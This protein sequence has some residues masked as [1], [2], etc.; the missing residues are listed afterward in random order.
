MEDLNIADLQV[1]DYM[2]QLLNS[3][4]KLAKVSMLSNYLCELSSGFLK[5][6]QAEELTS[7]YGNNRTKKAAGSDEKTA[8]RALT[9]LNK[10]CELHLLFASEKDVKEVEKKL[11]SFKKSLTKKSSG[12]SQYESVVRYGLNA[13][14]KEGTGEKANKEARDKTD[15]FSKKLETSSSLEMSMKLLQGLLDEIIA[16]QGEKLIGF[17]GNLLDYEYELKF[18][19]VKNEKYEDI[20]KNFDETKHAF[21]AKEVALKEN[22]LIITRTDPSNLVKVL[23]RF[24]IIMSAAFPHLKTYTD[25]RKLTEGT[26]Q[27]WLGSEVL[28]KGWK[29]VQYINKD[30]DLISTSIDYLKKEIN[31]LISFKKSGVELESSKAQCLML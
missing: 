18:D 16:K 12:D 10:L 2:P 11:D 3:E 20:I 24:A 21:C 28:D 6:I 17:M 25:S 1:L 19:L 26:Y 9:M 14:F 23:A 13:W 4:L 8:A 5:A 7:V 27:A 15:I 31:K 29:N 30:G 22:I